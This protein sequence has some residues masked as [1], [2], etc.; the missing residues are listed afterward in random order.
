MLVPSVKKVIVVPFVC[1]KATSSRCN[2][3][4]TSFFIFP[5]MHPAERNHYLNLRDFLIALSYLLF[6]FAFTCLL[7]CKSPESRI[8]MWFLLVSFQHRHRISWTWKK[9]IQP[10]SV[11]ISG[12]A[13]LMVQWFKNTSSL[14][15]GSSMDMAMCF[16]FV[17]K[18]KWTLLPFKYAMPFWLALV[19]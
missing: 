18:K 9:G 6:T 14:S 7:V 15:F 12:A 2:S 17:K 5:G 11:I 19:Y 8:C 1:L 16:D 4:F 13:H 10:I 3:S